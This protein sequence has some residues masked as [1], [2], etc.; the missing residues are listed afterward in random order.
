MNKIPWSRQDCDATTPEGWCLSS[1]S[2]GHL[3]I[4]R[5]DQPEDGSEP[6]FAGDDEAIAYVT[7]LAATGSDLHA[8]ALALD[9]RPNECLTAQVSP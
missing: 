5:I 3:E 9:G 2:H 7:E 6:R 8:R 1:T 4:Q